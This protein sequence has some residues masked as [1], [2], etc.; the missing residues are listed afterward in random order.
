MPP[1]S[2]NIVPECF[3]PKS[4]FM[5]DIV[6][7]PS[8]AKIDITKPNNKLSNIVKLTVNISVEQIRQEVVKLAIAPPIVLLGLISGAN[9][10]VNLGPIFD[11]TKSPKRMAKKYASIIYQHLSITN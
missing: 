11:A 8:C 9:F 3:M 6:R 7:S 5:L 1:Y 10:F 2:R 4:L